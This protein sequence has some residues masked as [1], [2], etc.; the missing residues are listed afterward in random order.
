MVTELFLFSSHAGELHVSN[1]QNEKSK[2]QVYKDQDHH[3]YTT[4]RREKKTQPTLLAV[5]KK[6]HDPDTGKEKLS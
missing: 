6:L 3:T 5:F 1:R 2:G 4:N